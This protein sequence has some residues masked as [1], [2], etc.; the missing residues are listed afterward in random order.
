M[1]VLEGNLANIQSKLFVLQLRKLRPR[2]KKAGFQR[3][4]LCQ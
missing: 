1:W 3:Y 4:P 2:E